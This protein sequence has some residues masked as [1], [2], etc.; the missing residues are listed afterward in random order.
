MVVYVVF[1]GRS[2]EHESSVTS[3]QAVLDCLDRSRYD[4]VSIGIT[5]EGRWLL[6]DDVAS[7]VSD[8]GEVLEG[9]SI[10]ESGDPVL[11]ALIRPPNR[12]RARA[13]RSDDGRSRGGPP[14]VFFPVLPGTY[15]EDGT[16]QG[17]FETAAVPYVGAGVLASAL[18]MDKVAAK[19][20]FQQAGLPVAPYSLVLRST[21]E[22]D[23]TAV[24]CALERDFEYPVFVKPANSGSS[25]GVN[26]AH[27]RH[28][29]VGALSEAAEWDRRLVVE[30]AIDG[31]EI[32]LGVLGNEDP[33]VSIP[34]EVVPSAGFYDYRDKHIDDTARELIPAP[35]TPDQ[36]RAAQE[37]SLSAFK[38]LDC[39]GMAR[40]DL[41]LDRGSGQLWVNEVN[42]LPAFRRKSMFPRLFEA[43]GYTYAQILDQL[44]ELALTRWSDRRRNRIR[45]DETAA[46]RR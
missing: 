20:A 16:I 7:V 10:E 8:G 6:V 29:L 42:T 43:M 17:A 25:L 15:G 2:G 13:R 19:A 21:W 5:R 46:S 35:L 32:E 11:Q 27:D 36:T 41:L 38:A 28:G 4:V 30:T 22:R 40:V 9:T 26:K 31:R 18:A 33:L 24:V 34:G 12:G 1:G 37:L 39:C 44:V 45:P 3:A 23:P 14:A